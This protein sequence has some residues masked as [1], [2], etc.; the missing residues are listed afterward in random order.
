MGK[1]VVYGLILGI[2]LII[3][4]YSFG[5]EDAA[6]MQLYL[7]GSAIFLALMLAFLLVAYGSL[8]YKQKDLI[9]LLDQGDVNAFLSENQKLL[10][11]AKF[12]VQK[13]LIRINLCAAFCDLEAYEDA[14]N[15]LDNIEEKHLMN[16]N[17]VVYWIN[18]IHVLNALGRKN[19]AMALLEDKR[20][21]LMPYKNSK[22]LGG[23]IQHALILEQIELGQLDQAKLMLEK[24]KMTWQQPR[25]Q[26]YFNK[27]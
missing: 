7:I 17:K 20:K 23:Y 6:F 21:M 1:T 25:L 19:E 10:D 14:L 2:I 27:L 12:S 18:R 8:A 24:A 4:K 3:F 15:Q 11:N 9:K 13:S 16:M 26:R 22:H 5:M